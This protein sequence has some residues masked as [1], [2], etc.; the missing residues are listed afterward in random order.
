MANTRFAIPMVEV[1]APDGRKEYWAAAL[2]HKDAV[3]AVRAAIPAD[4]MAELSLRRLPFGPK[5]EGLRRGEVRKV[6]P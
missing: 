1:T 3:A 6:Q 2:A 4:H 5:L